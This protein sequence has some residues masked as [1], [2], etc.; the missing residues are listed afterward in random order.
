[1]CSNFFKRHF[2]ILVLAY[3]FADWCD[4]CEL[5]YIFEWEMLL[6]CLIFY[7]SKVSGEGMQWTARITALYFWP[8]LMKKL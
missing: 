1:M 6:S 7:N 5:I 8:L 4:S 3:F 2:I